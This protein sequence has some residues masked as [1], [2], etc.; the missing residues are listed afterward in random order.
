[1]DERRADRRANQNGELGVMTEERLVRERIAQDLRVAMKARDA[2]RVAALRSFAAALDNATAVPMPSRIFANENVEVSRKALSQ[3]DVRAVLMR[4]IAERRD[5]AFTLTA[6]AC[7][8]EA[9]SVEA[10]IETLEKYID[11]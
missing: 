8:E 4:E 10:E 6:H 1:M 7:F 9:A 11:W 2:S 5:A 3:A